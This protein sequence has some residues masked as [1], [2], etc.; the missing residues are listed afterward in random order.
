MSKCLY[1]GNNPI[2]HFMHWANQS[3]IILM[4]PVNIFFVRVGIIS[5]IGKFFDKLF[6]LWWWL[7]TKI[8]LAKLHGDKEKI[9]VDR[10]KVLWEEA[11]RRGIKMQA[12]QLFGK[13]IDFYSAQIG[14]RNI[15]FTGLP[16]PE[17]HQNSEIEFWIDDKAIL[18]KKLSEAGVP[19]AKGGSYSSFTE[20]KKDFQQ[21]EKPV[22]IKPR[23]GSRG[24]HTTTFIYNEEQ[25]EK[26][27]KIAKQLCHWVVMEEHLVGSVYRGTVIGGKLAGVLGGSPPR[28]S[29]DGV[30]T[31]KELVQLKNNNKDPRVKD[32]KITPATVEFLSRNGLTLNSVLPEGKT[33]D[34]TEKIGISYGG[35]SFEITE[36]TH[37]E[38]KQVLEKAA[39]VVGDPLLGF[40]FII[41]NV[42]VDPKNQKWGIIECNGMPFINLHHDPLIGKPNNVAKFV[43]DLHVSP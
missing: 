4:T 25:L 37:P 8:G 20:L 27:F 1:C 34:I 39:G 11:D 22:I 41:E 29:G 17:E 26:G 10:A 12:A 30:H 2:P 36:E 28:I 38:I 23:L 13:N 7:F 21:L 35:T 40:D 19:V 33:I 5:R 6:F 43:W 15:F 24:R 31:I 3:L 14:E 16:R 32:I 18:K 9:S 42:S